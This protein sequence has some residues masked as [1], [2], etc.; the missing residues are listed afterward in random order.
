[1]RRN[2]GVLVAVAALVTGLA[3][4][5][6][7]SSSAKPESTV[8]KKAGLFGKNTSLTVVTQDYNGSVITLCADGAACHAETNLGVG[9]SDSVAAEN[10]H[11]WIRFGPK[12]FGH[13]DEQEFTADFNAYNPDVGHPYIQVTGLRDLRQSLRPADDHFNLA[14]GETLLSPRVYC[15]DDAAERGPTGDAY[16]YPDGDPYFV[17][18]LFAASRAADTDYKMLTLTV[19]N[20]N[21]REAE[22]DAVQGTEI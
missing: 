13:G 22:C 19:Y 18:F 9:G 14:E 7:D 4:C 5:G 11:G 12:S 21:Q 16:R 15:G 1:M 10:P 2:F 20:C 6:S 17:D 3:A 8:D